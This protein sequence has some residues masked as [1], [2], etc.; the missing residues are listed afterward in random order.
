ML[1]TIRRAQAALED[2]EDD[3]PW[4]DDLPQTEMVG[5]SRQMVEIYK[6]ISKVAGTDATILITGETGTGKELIASLIHRNSKRADRPFQAVDCGSIPEALLESELF[7]AQKGAFTGADK[8]RIGI[9]EAANTGTV[10]LDEI[11]EIPHDFQV[12]L[13]RVLQESEIKPVGAPRA[14]K[15]DVRVICATNRSLPKMVEEGKFRLD[16]WYRINTVIIDLPPL[17]ERRGDVR[18]LAQTFLAV[19][20]EITRMSKLPDVFENQKWYE[21]TFRESYLHSD[22]RKI[23]L[24]Y[25]VHLVLKDP[26][27]RLV[28]RATQKLA[29]AFSRAKSLVW[30]LLIQAILN[31]QKLQQGLEDYGTSL[32]KE[33][34]FREYLRVLASSKLFPILKEVLC[35]AEYKERMDK[36]RYDFLRSKE[37]FNQ[38]KEVGAEKFGWLKKSL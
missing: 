13:L 27:Q 4:I 10:F 31:D 26:V 3:S 33:A 7:G 28:E 14:K 8:D 38:C 5:N 29:L 9:F 19:Q 1:E 17:R 36:E 18:P 35:R 24:A 15:I 21:D 16:L 37:V 22:A 12:R 23:V 34:T 32:R 6:T 2:T 25:K 30:A 11:G 20:G